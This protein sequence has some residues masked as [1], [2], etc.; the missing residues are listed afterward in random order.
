MKG[1]SQVGEGEQVE[2]YVEEVGTWDMFLW[3][4]HS[5]ALFECYRV[6]LCLS[7]G[8]TCIAF[9]LSAFTLNFRRNDLGPSG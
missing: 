4:Q 8:S 5:V 1:S 6:Y 9:A 7:P 3:P 2:G